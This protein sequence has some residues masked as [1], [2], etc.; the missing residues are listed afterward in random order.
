MKKLLAGISILLLITSCHPP[1]RYE[2]IHVNEGVTVIMDTQ[3]GE[4]RVTTI[5]YGIIISWGSCTIEQLD[6]I[7]KLDDPVL[8]FDSD[9]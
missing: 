6:S 3:T 4:C 1:G 8:R 9:E 7:A 5:D 2:M